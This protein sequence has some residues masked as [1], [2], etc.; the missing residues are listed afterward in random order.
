MAKSKVDVRG[1]S[2][3]ERGV[4]SRAI[5]R[6]NKS[7][8]TRIRCRSADA[9]G[10]VVGDPDAYGTIGGRH[11]EI[12]F[13][14]GSGVPSK[15][16]WYEL[17]RWAQAGACCAVIYS[18]GQALAFQQ[19]VLAGRSQGRVLVFGKAA[20][21]VRQGTCGPGPAVP[22]TT[23]GSGGGHQEMVEPGEGSDI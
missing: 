2:A 20:E 9:V 3:Q 19:E 10:H 22:F 17:R 14:K 4:Q 6:L 11:V 13:K 1:S 5:K 12:E 7:P 23:I 21:Q 18:I 8:G 16:Q 15:K